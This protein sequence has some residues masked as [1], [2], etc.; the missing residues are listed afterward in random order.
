MAGPQMR[1][2]QALPET[3]RKSR[4][5]AHRFQLR[6][7]P[8]VIQ[9]FMIA[10]VL[11]GETM[12]NAMLQSRCVTDPIDNP[13]IGW[14]LE[15]Y[16]FYCPFSCLPHADDLKE[17]MISQ[18]ATLSN[19]PTAAKQAHYHANGPDFV[20][21][22]LQAVTEAFFRDAGV[23]WDASGQT[24]TQDSE[25]MPIAGLRRMDSWLDSVF[26]VTALPTSDG[27]VVDETTGLYDELDERRLMYER[28]RELGMTEA[29]YEDW[30]RMNGVTAEKEA[31]V[32]RPELLRESSK[33][34]YPTNTIDPTT[35]DPS[36]AVSWAIAEEASKAR[37]F[38][39]PGFILG[40]CVVRP[41]VY[42]GR[43]YGNA[44]SL[45]NSA[46]NWMPAMAHEAAASIIEVTKTVGPLG[47]GV[48]DATSPSHNYIV[49]LRDLLLYGDQ[50]M[51]FDLTATDA[52][53]VA[54]PKADLTKRFPSSAD[55]QALFVGT[56][57][58]TG[59]VRQDGVCMLNILGKQ[60]DQT[61]FST[62]QTS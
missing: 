30:L 12:K 2:V 8:Y 61:T 21:E 10:P 18:S 7:R 39:E 6:Q 28:I 9:P 29:T 47:S 45:F 51:N 1:V 22:C 60:T 13:L 26:D 41:K 44:A 55:I 57:E 20:S 58:A 24:I 52:G 46:L 54:L 56:T 16:L 35:G 49:D 15:H 43:Q 33:W 32:S 11:P 19:V 62:L 3:G 5:P 40:V 34:S 31:A 4:R 37:F 25:T 27:A 14:W 36:S 42:L 53:I 23:A 38:K 59:L 50:F 48:A 17:L